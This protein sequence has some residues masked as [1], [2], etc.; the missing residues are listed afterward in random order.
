MV[1]RVTT[2]KDNQHIGASRDEQLREDLS[3]F[4]GLTEW[5]DAMQLLGTGARLWST[6]CR[7]ALLEL[8]RPIGGGDR[9][10]RIRRLILYFVN[11]DYSDHGQLALFDAATFWPRWLCAEV[12]DRLIDL[13]DFVYPSLRATGD[14]RADQCMRLLMSSLDLLRAHGLPGSPVQTEIRSLFGHLDE[15]GDEVLVDPLEGWNWN[16]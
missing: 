1:A 6:D 13:V 2:V 10:D 12:A 4:L 8:P 7:K 5:F 9:E 14:A 16:S 3:L 11:A 15:L